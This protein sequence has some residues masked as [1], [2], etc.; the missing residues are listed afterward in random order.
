MGFTHTSYSIHL[1]S[2]TH[3]YINWDK[4]HHH[5]AVIHAVL[6]PLHI[7]TSTSGYD[8][9]D[10]LVPKLTMTEFRVPTM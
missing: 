8:N 4:H 3:N 2:L 6:S 1:T 7:N 5:P 9:I 10:F